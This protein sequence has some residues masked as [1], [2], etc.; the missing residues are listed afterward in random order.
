[1]CHNGQH[2]LSD[3]TEE[4]HM[5]F[6][7]LG[8]TGMK[9]SRLCLGTMTFGWSADEATSFAV[10][11]RAF[12]AGIN[13]FDTANIYSY[14]GEGNQG[15][16]SETIIGKW[17]KTKDRRQ[18]MLA[19]KVRG[20]MWAG[21]SGEG[22]SRQHIKHAVE[23]SLRRLQTDYIDLYQ[24]HHI[25]PHT[26]HEETLA[27]LDQLVREGKVLYIG[28]SNYPAWQLVKALWMSDKHGFVRFDS[29]QPHYS[30]FHRREFE[31]ELEAVCRDQH[32]AVL[33]YSPL[34]AGF[35]TGKFTRENRVRSTPRAEYS[36]LV[37]RLIDDERAYNLLDGIREIAQRCSVPMAHVAIAW[38]LANPV[39]TAPI[40]GVR[41]VEQLEE[42]LGAEEL[43]LDSEAITRLN[44]LSAGF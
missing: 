1:M 28:C 40:I 7:Q 9:V 25:D 29:L 44:E 38:L 39:V 11:D 23:D 8:R 27:A 14:W 33:P 21:P 17:L 41:T 30:L 4:I 19:T 36:G 22:L 20:R 18:I 12:D 6:V 3:S 10:M 35:A 34:A 42:V 32:I 43:L 5:Q 37:A 24:T 13:F 15:G 31:T 16:E 26:P 2:D